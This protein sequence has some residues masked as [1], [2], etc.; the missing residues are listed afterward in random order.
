MTLRSLV[1]KIAPNV[2]IIIIK[3]G[4]TDPST[5]KHMTGYEA[6]REYIGSTA[7]VKDFRFDN[8]ILIITI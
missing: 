8:N 3:D 2:Q 6:N 7:E 1:S 5:F 4:C